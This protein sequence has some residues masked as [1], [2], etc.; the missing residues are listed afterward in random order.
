MD[1]A[2]DMQLVR[3]YVDDGYS[4]LYFRIDHSFSR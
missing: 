1:K 3:M 4:G 2:G